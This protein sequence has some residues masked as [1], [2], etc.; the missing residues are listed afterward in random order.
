[1][2]NDRVALATVGDIG[3]GK[4]I[5]VQLTQNGSKVALASR[6]PAYLESAAAELRALGLSILR[7]QMDVR[8]NTRAHDQHFLGAGKIGVPGSRP[9]ALPIMA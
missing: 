3:I 8:A 9:T 2:L 5:G 4:A 6:N 7:L 1:M